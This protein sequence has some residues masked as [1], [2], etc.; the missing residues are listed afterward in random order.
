MSGMELSPDLVCLRTGI[1]N[2][3]LYGLP[4]AGDRG[5]VLIDAG[6][7]GF[8]G[9]IRRTAAER[10]GPHARPAAIVLTHG[11]FDHVGALRTL[12]ERWD[13][14]IYAHR[15]EL[16][17]LT[18]QS[19]YPPPDPWVGGGAM[20]LLS[21]LYPRGPFDVREWIQVLPEDGSV[22]GMQA[23]RWFHT[24]GHAPG[25][26]AFFRD[27]DGTLVA[28]DAFVTTKQESALSAVTW[29]PEIHGPPAYFTPDWVAACRSVELLASLEPEIAATGHGPPLR[30][31]Q[32]REGL[33]RLS[34]HFHEL[35]VPKHGRYTHRP[36]ITGP[37]GLVSAPPPVGPTARQAAVG[38]ALIGI[39]GA[40][41][42]RSRRG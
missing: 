22:P 39:A 29:K 35:A 26:V 14:P 3:Y 11:H 24:P 42:M 41:L 16:P 15:L 13:V 28:G 20:A 5:W 9:R 32:M 31:P 27:A 33:R 12:A 17:Y 21:P 30:G 19:P 1:V 2:V 38:A 4:G 8:A 34:R 6:L 7:Q 37:Y 10:F 18:G 25:H 40:A 23:W 36:A